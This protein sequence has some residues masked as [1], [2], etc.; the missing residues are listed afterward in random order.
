M[1]LWQLPSGRETVIPGPADGD[2][3]DA[4]IT[5]RDDKPW[6]FMEEFVSPRIGALSRSAVLLVS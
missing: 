1:K 4:F 3:A 2:D 6:F 5:R